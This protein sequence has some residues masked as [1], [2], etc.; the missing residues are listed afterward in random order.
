MTGRRRRRGKSGG[1]LRLDD[2]DSA[3]AVDSDGEGAD[4]NG[5]E[6]ATMMVTSP[7]D[8]DDDVSDDVTTG[9]DRTA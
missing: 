4:E 3:P 7:T 1:N 8:D 5:D 6:T 2:G 9:G